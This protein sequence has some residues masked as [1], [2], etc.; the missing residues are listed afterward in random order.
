M[1]LNTE[2]GYDSYIEWADGR[3]GENVKTQID[4]IGLLLPGTAPIVT[5]MILENLKKAKVE[6]SQGFS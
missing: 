5:I 4:A 2:D 3:T 1:S 6:K